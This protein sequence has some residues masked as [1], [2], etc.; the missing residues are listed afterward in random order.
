MNINIVL[1]RLAIVASLHE[2][3]LFRVGKQLRVEG[4]VLSLSCVARVLRGQEHEWNAEPH[5]TGPRS[6]RCVGHASEPES[7]PSVHIATLSNS[8][9]LRRLVQEDAVLVESD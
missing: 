2:A 5:H 1:L 8:I 4:N 9:E 7:S 3:D 6:D